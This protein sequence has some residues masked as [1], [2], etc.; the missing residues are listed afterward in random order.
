MDHLGSLRV[1]AGAIQFIDFGHRLLINTR[2]IY[3]SVIA[4][5]NLKSHHDTAKEIVLKP[6][7]DDATSENGK[8]TPEDILCRA[9]RGCQDVSRALLEAINASHGKQQQKDKQQKNRLDTAQTSRPIYYY[10]GREVNPTL[11]SFATALREVWSSKTVKAYRDQLVEYLAQPTTASLAVPW[12]KSKQGAQQLDE[13]SRQQNHM[14][15]TLGQV[16]QTTDS[17]N[18]NLIQLQKILN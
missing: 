18:Q 14:L 16:Q 12:E 10:F 1:A 8:E 6:E 15:E 2:E 13:L 17:L 9:C 4:S 7:D 5:D 11:G 3:H